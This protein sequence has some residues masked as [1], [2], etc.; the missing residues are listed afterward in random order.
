[1]EEILYFSIQLLNLKSVKRCILYLIVFTC[2]FINTDQLFSQSDSIVQVSET[3]E[4]KVSKKDIEVP[5]G[6]GVDLFLFTNW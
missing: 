6:A 4:N 3:K 1:M 5:E 2:F